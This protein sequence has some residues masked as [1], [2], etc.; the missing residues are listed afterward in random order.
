MGAFRWLAAWLGAIIFACIRKTCRLRTHNDPR[1]GLRGVRQGYIYAILHAH[2]IAAALTHGEKLCGTMVSR[3]V[4]G[5]LL[6]PTCTLNNIRPFRG[7][8]SKKGRDKGGTGALL[9]LIEFV[10]SGHPCTMAVDG[11]RGP[12]NHVH[13]G[14]AK[15]AEAT[16][17]HIV[18]ACVIPRRRWIL[19]GTWDRMQLPGPFS[20]FDAWFTEPI[21]PSSFDNIETLRTHIEDVLTALEERSD[22]KEAAIASERLRAREKRDRC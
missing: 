4:D 11:P 18:V 15:I 9:Q 14:V 10:G 17:A 22:P 16:G 5:D 2:Q 12:R 7:S 1:P 19:R 13:G 6:I 21:D 8:S 3:S 20:T